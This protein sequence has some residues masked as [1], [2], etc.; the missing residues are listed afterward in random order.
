M[1]CARA[2]E[3]EAAAKLLR[4]SLRHVSLG[5]KGRIA[6]DKAIAEASSD[7]KPSVPSNAAV[8]NDRWRLE[9]AFKILEEDI[10]Q[11]W[12]ATLA[13]LIVGGVDIEF[14]LCAFGRLM[15]AHVNSAIPVASLFAVGGHVL[16][17]R[18]ARW[19]KGQ[20][21][22]IVDGGFDVKLSSG[23]ELNGVA[24]ELVLT[25]GQR[26]AGGLICEAARMGSAPL[27]SLLV[28]VRA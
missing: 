26:G 5:E 3:H 16:V 22:R 4:L 15:R 6:I 2:G 18:G 23:H 28:Q 14:L 25:R 21:S 1:L 7:G 19:E 17:N 11:P 8:S 20:T 27:V 24:Q 12:P 13:L 10:V 9:A